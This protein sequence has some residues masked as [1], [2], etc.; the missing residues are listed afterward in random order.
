MIKQRDTLVIAEWYREA[1]GIFGTTSRDNET[2][3]VRLAFARS[4]MPIWPSLRA[5]CHHPDRVV[6]LGTRL[7][8][9]GV[10]LGA[11]G[12]WLGLAGMDALQCVRYGIEVFGL[13]FCIVLV[14]FAILAVRGPSR[15]RDAE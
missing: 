6:R 9:L 13:V 4:R 11:V 5:A 1:L 3:K 2:G 12:L 14:I 8:M 15:P 7:G 10:C